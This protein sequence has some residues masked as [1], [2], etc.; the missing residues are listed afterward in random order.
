MDQLQAERSLAIIRGVIENTRD[1][2]IER[3]WGLI[4]IVHSFINFAV[5]ASGAWI[6]RRGLPVYWYAVPL[7]AVTA[8]NIIVVLL[9][10]SREHGVR[11]YVEWQL[12]AIWI[13]FGAFTVLAIATLHFTGAKPS[14]FAPIFSMNCGICFA[15]MGVVFYK[16]FLAVGGLFFVVTLLA[17]WQ[18]DLQWWLIGAAW[19]LAMFLTGLSAHREHLRRRQHERRTEIL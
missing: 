6:D 9:F 18:P 3:N 10:M 13:V 8:L 12:W 19:W 17:L 15:M 16:R 14:L 7:A 5:C 1:D 4:W 11:S 2:L